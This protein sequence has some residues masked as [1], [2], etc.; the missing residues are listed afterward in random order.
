MREA[1]RDQSRPR[2]Q[3]AWR[4]EAGALLCFDQIRDSQEERKL[5]REVTVGLTGQ[6]KDLAFTMR[7]MESHGQV[8]EMI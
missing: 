5:T 1:R 8:S 3:P 4:P 6:C 7:E 2:S